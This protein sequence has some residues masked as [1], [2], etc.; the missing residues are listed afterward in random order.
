M[1]FRGEIARVDNDYYYHYHGVHV[2]GGEFASTDVW[3]RSNVPSPDQTCPPT[4]VGDRGHRD[5]GV[6]TFPGE[7]G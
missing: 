5:R 7:P 6:D 3:R 2:P 4:P 1:E